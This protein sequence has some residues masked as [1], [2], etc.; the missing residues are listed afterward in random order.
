MTDRERAEKWAD[1]LTFY[2]DN[3]RA[4]VPLDALV[5]PFLG[6]V[7]LSGVRIVRGADGIWSVTA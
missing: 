7:H 2:R 5:H 4:N 3:W 1:L 6:E